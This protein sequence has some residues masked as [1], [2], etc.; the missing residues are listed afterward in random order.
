[1]KAS[2]IP[3]C[4]VE[5]LCA[6][7]VFRRLQFPAEDIFVG[8]YDEEEA[9]LIG[10]AMEKRFL[11]IQVRQGGKTYEVFV[12]APALSKEIFLDLWVQACK[13]WSEGEE[14]I[15][16]AYWLNS[17]AKAKAVEMIIEINKAGLVIPGKKVRLKKVKGLMN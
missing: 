14:E 16:Q 13:A 9:V 11:A 10:G 15:I 5:A 17:D 8:L 12:A 3:P 4:F 7:E 1:M 6:H 2:E